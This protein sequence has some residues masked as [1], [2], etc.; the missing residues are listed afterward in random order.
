M[1]VEHG[2]DEARLSVLLDLRS[3]ASYLALPD[4]IEL[5]RERGL[6]INWL[7]LETAP[8]KPPGSAGPDADRGARHRRYRAEAIAREIA[9]YGGAQGLVLKD[10]YRDAPVDA[11][12]LA[13]LWVRARVPARLPEFL[14]ELF[15]AYWA[16]E[17]DGRDAASLAAKVDR[18]AADGAA[19][20]AW[21]RAEG[22]ARAAALQET[23]SERGLFG[24]PGYLIDGEVFVGRQ[25]L[26]MIRW[27]L[28]GRPGRG[29]I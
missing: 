15:R 17:I 11:A 28:D 25:H 20:R 4:A 5:G 23:L 14:G 12:V 22:P 3:P 27:I 29:P 16:V 21:S 24:V 6:A 8:L 2:I 7:P 26:P 9:V 10:L 18:V 13:W 1:K 19:Y